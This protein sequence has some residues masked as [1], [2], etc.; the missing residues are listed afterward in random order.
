MLV[1]V[2]T[3]S[4]NQKRFLEEAILS[5]LNQDY[6]FIQ[7]IVIDPGSNDGSRELINFYSS[8][9][10][11]VIFEIDNGPADGLRKGMS[12][13][14]GEILCYL[15][16]DDILLPNSISKIV[17]IF[18]K[19]KDVDIIYGNSWIID[20][21]G[22]KKRKFH[23][24]KFNLTMAKYGSC[25]IS[26]QSTFFRKSC[27]LKTAGF[28]PNNSHNWDLE[29]LIDFGLINCNFYKVNDF[30]SCFRVHK[31]SI[32]VSSSYKKY[33]YE[34]GI[35]FNNLYGRNYNIFDFLLYCLFKYLRKVIN[36]KDTIERIRNGPIIPPND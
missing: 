18:N 35:I 33:Q 7:Y 6:K 19:K 27:Y 9:I 4:Y 1:T 17:R 11:K 32:S 30:L 34:L 20:E 26:Q 28:N 2:V 5:V 24:D 22:R 25:I 12:F 21:N 31:N 13:A 10:S 29:L 3:I 8:K 36:L 23:S 14:N 16:S 15:N